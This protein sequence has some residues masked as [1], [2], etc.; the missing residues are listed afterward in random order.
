MSR[1]RLMARVN[2]RW[3]REHV[4]VARPAKIFPRSVI[5][6]RKKLTAFQSTPPCLSMQMRQ[7]RRRIGGRR[8]PG[9]EGGRDFP[10]PPGPPEP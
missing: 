1:A 6:F 4:P 5:K 10:A 2:C 8:P 3:Q 9:P 7:T